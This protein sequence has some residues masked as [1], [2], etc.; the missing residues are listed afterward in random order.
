MYRKVIY[1]IS[2]IG[3]VEKVEGET[4]EMK[5]E[6]V[7]DNGEPITDGAPEIYTERS[8]GV[9]SAYNIRTDRWEVA[10]EA[11]DKVSASVI[12]RRDNKPKNEPNMEVVKGGNE[13]N[14]ET[15]S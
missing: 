2:N 7:L 3:S 13:A 15:G 5:M 11:M 4:I 6:R 14:L 10:C 9:M 12:A 1:V 8:K